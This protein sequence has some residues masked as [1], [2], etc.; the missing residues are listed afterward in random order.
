MKILYIVLFTIFISCSSEYV[1]TRNYGN[2]KPTFSILQSNGIKLI[3]NQNFN[4]E[5]NYYFTLELENTTSEDL[6][7]SIKDKD[8]YTIFLR[9]GKMKIR[10]DQKVKTVR[11]GSVFILKPKIAHKIDFKLEKQH[12]TS[13]IEEAHLVVRLDFLG[14]LYQNSLPSIIIKQD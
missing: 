4:D 10:L 12:V 3:L 13:D 7:F 14:K 6:K 2:K 5:K 9:D 11:K 8:Y 1:N